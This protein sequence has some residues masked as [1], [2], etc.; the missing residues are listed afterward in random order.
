MMKMMVVMTEQGPD[1]LRPPNM[2]PLLWPDSSQIRIFSPDFP[3]E[4]QTC[5]QSLHYYI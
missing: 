1:E 4:L 2:Q 5:F 3:S